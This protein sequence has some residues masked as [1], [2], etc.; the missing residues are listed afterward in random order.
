MSVRRLVCGKLK[1]PA[2]WTCTRDLGHAGPCAAVPCRA[3]AIGMTDAE[4]DA[5][6]ARRTREIQAAYQPIPPSAPKDEPDGVRVK[7]RWTRIAKFPITARKFE[8]VFNAQGEPLV[9]RWILACKFAL[10]TCR[11][12]PSE[13]PRAATQKP[14]TRKNPSAGASRQGSPVPPAG[15]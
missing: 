15:L 6:V 8:R 4:F 11:R 2:G 3:D 7:P 10:A 5:H 13:L 1:A 12:T 14:P 9:A